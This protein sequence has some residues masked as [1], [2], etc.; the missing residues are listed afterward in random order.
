MKSNLVDLN[1]HYHGM[2]RGALI[3]SENGDKD[4]LIYLPLSQIEYELNHERTEVEVTLPEW[5]A[6]QKDLI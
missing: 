5:L 3:V 4:K 6:E 1:L 2:A